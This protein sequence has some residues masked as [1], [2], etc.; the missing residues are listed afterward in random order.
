[1]EGQP[2]AERMQKQMI[3]EIEAARPM[4]VVFVNVPTSWMVRKSSVKS[5][6]NW[7]NGYVGNLY[8]QVGVIDIISPST[9]RYLWDDKSAGYTPVSPYY[10]GVFKRKG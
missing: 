9:T 5:V 8:E 10:V 4:Y 6:L 7:A 2:Y 3:R 1:M